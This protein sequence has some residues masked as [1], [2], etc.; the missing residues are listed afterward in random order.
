MNCISMPHPPFVL[1]STSFCICSQSDGMPTF[2]NY[3]IYIF[4]VVDQ[5]FS[6]IGGHEY[7][8]SDHC[9]WN[10]SEFV[11]KVGEKYVFHETEW[12]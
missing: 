12:I 9:T 7:H 1:N 8:I 10:S 5:I 11:Y 2:G 6:F 3:P 4:F